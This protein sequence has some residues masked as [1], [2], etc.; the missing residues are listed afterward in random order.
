MKSICIF[1]GS[2]IGNDPEIVKIAEETGKFFADNNIRLVYG[3]G[4]VGLMGVVSNTVMKAGG[5]T[6]GVIPK[7]MMNK[8]IANFNITELIEV[9]SMH[10]RKAKMADLSDGFIV[11]PGGIGTMDEFF[12]IWTWKQLKLHSK[13]IGIFNYKGFYDPLLKFI[14]DMIANGFL[15]QEKF[16]EICVSDS[17]SELISKMNEKE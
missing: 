5:E 1:C 14:K 7:F 4:N 8:E 12:E 6:T 9:T 3:G 16:D 13:P 17:I 2:A 11:L 15:N 10:E